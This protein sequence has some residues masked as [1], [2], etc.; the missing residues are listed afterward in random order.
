MFTK[1]RFKALQ[2]TICFNSRW[3]NRASHNRSDSPLFCACAIDCSTMF[4]LGSK[5]WRLLWKRQ[6]P[7]SCEWSKQSLYRRLESGLSGA[8]RCVRVTRARCCGCPWRRCVRRWA[9]TRCS[10]AP[11]IC[12][13]MCWRD[14]CS[15]WPGAA[16]DT[17]S[18]VSPLTL[19]SNPHN[20]L[21]L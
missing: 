16:T 4:R 21:C 12:C 20:S 10:W 18:S 15:S 6:C 7:Y 17:P 14:T 3:S 2:T 1:D 9:G 11:V 19:L 8:E 13:P 5:R